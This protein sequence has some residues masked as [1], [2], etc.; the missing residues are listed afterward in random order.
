M[1]FRLVPKLV[2]EPNN[3]KRRNGRCVIL[4]RQLLGPLR[5]SGLR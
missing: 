3:P 2:T 4:I 1:G 5:Q